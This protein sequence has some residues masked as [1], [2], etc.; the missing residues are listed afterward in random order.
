MGEG[1]RKVCSTCQGKK[2]V[3]GVCECSTEWRGTQSDD[4]WE[5]CQCTPEVSCPTCKG[6]GYI[7][8]AD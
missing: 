3:E 2:V 8:S 4:E 6:T 7:E 1:M 5:E